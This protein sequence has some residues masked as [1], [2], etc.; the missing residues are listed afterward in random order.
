MLKKCFC[1]N[2]KAKAPNNIP[3]DSWGLFPL[4]LPYSLGENSNLSIIKKSQNENINFIRT[5]NSYK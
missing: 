5:F 3:L 4:K 2:E 1:Q